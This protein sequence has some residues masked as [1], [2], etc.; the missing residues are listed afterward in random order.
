MLIEAWLNTVKLSTEVNAYWN[1]AM[2]F[3]QVKCYRCEISE[4]KEVTSSECVGQP[5]PTAEMLKSIL[6]EETKSL[7]TGMRSGLM[8]VMMN[9]IQYGPN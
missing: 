1:M 8:W 5:I 2:L 6:S 4:K 7:N 3:D 9:Y